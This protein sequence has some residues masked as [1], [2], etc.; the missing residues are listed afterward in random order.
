MY[1]FPKY[2]VRADTI[3]RAMS[4][5]KRRTFISYIFGLGTLLWLYPN[6]AIQHK[7]SNID[8]RLCVAKGWILRSDDLI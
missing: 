3:G 8:V 5:I 4:R 2:L 1:I 6:K 7:S